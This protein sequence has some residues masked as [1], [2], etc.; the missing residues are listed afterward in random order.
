M[1]LLKDALKEF[2][3]AISLKEDSLVKSM[4]EKR[5]KRE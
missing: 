1:D 2:S 5:E 4:H 3:K